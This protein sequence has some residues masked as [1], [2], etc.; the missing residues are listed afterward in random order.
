[1][2][3]ASVPSKLSPPRIQSPLIRKHLIRRLEVGPGRRLTII[4]GRAAQG[5]TT[6]MATYVA[7]SK[8]PFAW[9]NLDSEESDPAALYHLIV[10]ALA[11]Y[12]PKNGLLQLMS[13]PTINMGPRQAMSRRKEWA[14][15]L[16][17]WVTGPLQIIFDGADRMLPDAP[18]WG[19]FQAMVDLLPKNLH[20]FIIS[21]EPPNIDCGKWSQPGEINILTDPDLNFS[22]RETGIFLRK[23]LGILPSEEELQKVQRITEGWIGGLILLGGM[24]RNGAHDFGRGI[25][26]G[27]PLAQFQTTVNRYF[28][29]AIFDGQPETVQNF[30][31]KTSIPDEFD[32]HLL[33]HL[34]PETDNA[35]IVQS[36]L[37]RNLF[38]ELYERPS[39]SPIYRFHSLF[40]DYLAYKRKAVWPEGKIRRLYAETAQYFEKQS[41]DISAAQFYLRSHHF[42]EAVALI[43]RFGS[44]L[45]KEGRHAI[46]ADMLKAFPPEIKDNQP[47]LLFF[48][49]MLARFTE[50]DR[51]ISRLWKA[52]QIFDSQGRVDGRILCLAFLLEATIMRGRDIIPLKKLLDHANQL[53]NAVGPQGLDWEKALLWLNTG[54]ALTIRGGEPRSGFV[55]CQNAWL[56]AAKAGDPILQFSALI[57][58]GIAV[59]WLGEFHKL[60]G[61]LRNLDIL[62]KRIDYPELSIM[63]EKMLS[64]MYLF[65]G[66]LLPARACMDK[67]D[68]A[69]SEMGLV[70]LVPLKLYSD[71]LLAFYSESYGEAQ[72][73]SE[74]LFQLCT[75]MDHRTGMAMSLTFQGANFYWQG[76]FDAAVRCF[77]DSLAIYQEPECRAGLHE[78]WTHL[79]LALTELHLGQ[80]ESAETRIRKSLA[81]FR[82][83][84]SNTFIS[85]ALLS[86]GFLHI[87]R[88]QIEAAQAC[89]VEAFELAE[90]YGVFHFAIVR[91]VDAIE[92]CTRTLEMNID[93]R[94]DYIR[95]LLI[96][97]FG[98][99]ACIGLS[100]VADAGTPG[101]RAKAL[102][103]LKA[104]R[105]RALPRI[106]IRTLGA[107]QVC[108]DETPIPESEW[109]GTRSKDFLKALVSRGGRHIPKEMLIEDLWP[110]SK[111]SGEGTFKASLHRLRRV[112][113]P[114]IDQKIGSIYLVLQDNLVSLNPD[115]CDVDAFRF[116]LLC[117]N[118][119]IEEKAH[120]TREALDL[121]LAAKEIYGGDFLPTDRYAPWAEPMRRRLSAVYCDLLSRIGNLYE[122]RGALHKACQTYHCLL[123]AE[124]LDETACRR[125]MALYARRGLPNKADRVYKT[126]RRHLEKEFGEHLDPG[127]EALHRGIMENKQA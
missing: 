83:I 20:L 58:A 64:E 31:L 93:D 70:Y 102:E 120:R 84:R 41:R 92:I 39:A 36:L 28:D 103:I 80:W 112:L 9:V 115:L 53:G 88:N 54:L 8:M 121:C 45:V 75:A 3:Y 7:Q 32:M 48:T 1:M 59:T 117:E 124:P 89:L 66:D 62:E 77:C 51:N 4:Q 95:Q 17:Q 73:I 91:P 50:A 25:L 2:M 94:F 29:E 98:T 101:A 114:E 43:E 106:K 69:I 82:R 42:S 10:L 11:P 65:R 118:A 74:Q 81:Y 52:Y 21:R 79:L 107:F 126:Y 87:R 12:L 40:R 5:K 19:L 6:L 100:A 33:N 44:T 26:N 49:S 110:E 22:R 123:D 13:Y 55:A 15:A 27:G 34:L 71:F 119:R 113:E 18:S 78:N 86:M 127:L 56:F 76:H 46:L 35:A 38:I 97:K 47:W 30:L 105:T 122:Q 24:I 96:R 16:F 72:K 23:N 125:L 37:D 109:K 60:P 104:I 67:L 14:A 63:K 99:R 116:Q 57:N 108:R 61:L 90:R 111:A 85:E 68:R